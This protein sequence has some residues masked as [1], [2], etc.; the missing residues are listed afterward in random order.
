MNTSEVE[1]TQLIYDSENKKFDFSNFRILDGKCVIIKET[2]WK[3]T[4]GRGNRKQPYFILT[5]GRVKHSNQLKKLQKED[6]RDILIQKILNN[7]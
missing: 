2:I 5:D 3:N 6:I 1:K 7:E 4:K